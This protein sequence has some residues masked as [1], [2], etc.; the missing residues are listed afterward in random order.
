MVCEALALFVRDKTKPML[1]F[2]AKDP[3]GACER[4]ELQ[5]LHEKDTF[6]LLLP[7]FGSEVGEAFFEIFVSH[8]KEVSRESYY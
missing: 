7:R 6:L 3:R 2:G 8:V 5:R 4:S 1:H